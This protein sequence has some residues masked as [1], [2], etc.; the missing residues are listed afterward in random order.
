M[1]IGINYLGVDYHIALLEEERR[2]AAMLE[3]LLQQTCEQSQYDPLVDSQSLR[4]CTETVQAVKKSIQW[5][6]RFLAGLNESMQ[7][8][9]EQIYSILSELEETLT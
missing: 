4:K 6:M 5:R 2:S 9:A 8:N 3:E 7:R 1:R